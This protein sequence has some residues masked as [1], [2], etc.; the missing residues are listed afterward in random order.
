MPPTLIGYLVSNERT[1]GCSS[2]GEGL[3]AHSRF[4]SSDRTTQ[5]NPRELNPQWFTCLLWLSNPEIIVDLQGGFE[6]VDPQIMERW[7]GLFGP[8]LL[9]PSLLARSVGNNRTHSSTSFLL[10]E[11]PKTAATIAVSGDTHK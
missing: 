5:S 2:G 11:F 9:P 1:N 10:L 4:L 3:T 7:S 6:R 8:W